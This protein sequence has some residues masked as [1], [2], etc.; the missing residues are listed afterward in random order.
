MPRII[1]WNTLALCQEHF[2]GRSS[3]SARIVGRI[4][5]HASAS[6]TRSRSLGYSFLA[7]AGLNPTSLTGA[8]AGL[9]TIDT[10]LRHHADVRGNTI[11]IRMLQYVVVSLA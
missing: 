6:T 8:P 11:S 9:A 5:G 7:T 2:P 10:P 4:G 3:A 1:I